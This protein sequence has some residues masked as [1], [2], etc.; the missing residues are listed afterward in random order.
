MIKNI[1]ELAGIILCLIRVLID[2]ADAGVG[3]ATQLA[4]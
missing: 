4:E 3:T 1:R 2:T